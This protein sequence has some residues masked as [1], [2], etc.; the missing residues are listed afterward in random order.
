M[1]AS[2]DT[3]RPEPLILPQNPRLCA[4]QPVLAM[5]LRNLIQMRAEALGSF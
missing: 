2:S 1:I 3:N 5:D 4:C